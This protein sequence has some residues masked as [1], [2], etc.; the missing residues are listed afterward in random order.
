MGSTRRGPRSRRVSHASRRVQTPPMPVDQSTARRSGATS[1]APASAQASR[2]GD[3]RELADGSRRLVSWRSSTSV[4]ATLAVAAKVTGSSYSL[5]PVVLERAGA[6]L[7]GEQGVPAV[8]GGSAERRGRADA[9]DD[10][11]LGHGEITPWDGAGVTRAAAGARTPYGRGARRDQRL[12]PGL[13]D[14][15]DGVADGLEVLDLFVGD[16]DVELLLGVD[17]DRHHRDRVDVEV[18][19][20]RLV[21]LDRVGRRCRSRR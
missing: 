7:A 15:V 17:D 12:R 14:E 2:A 18:V 6:G 11:L 10:D 8:G 5:D 16:L 20:E 3:Q 1:G 21:Q 13:D 19:G 4:G 9:G